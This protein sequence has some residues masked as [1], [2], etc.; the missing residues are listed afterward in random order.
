MLEQDKQADRYLFHKPGVAEGITGMLMR[1]SLFLGM[2]LITACPVHAQP[3]SWQ[4]G[5]AAV[6]ITPAAPMW[7]AGYASRDHVSDGTIHPL[8]VKALALQDGQ[9]H[10]AVIVTSDV[11]GFPK[12]MSVRICERL[13]K[14]LNLARA[15]ILLNSSHTHSG[16]VIL[17]SLMCMYPLDAAGLELVKQETARIEDAVV[18]AAE[19][20]FAG[21][22]PARLSSGGGTVRFAVNRR[23][24]AEAEVPSLNELKGPVDHAVP[25]LL[26]AGEDGAPIAVL[27]GYACHATVLSGFQWCG[28]YPGFAQIEV[29]KAHPGAVAMFAAGCGADINPLPRRSVELARQYGRELAFAVDEVLADTMKPLDPTLATR[30]TETELQLEAAP[31]RA[32]FEE[33]RA[34]AA[35]YMSNA[36]ADQL[37]ELDA[38]RP[39]RSSYPYCAQLWRIGNQTLV[40]LGGEVVVDYAITIKRMLGRETFVFGF[41]NDLMSYIPSLRVLREGGYEG[42]ASQ[43]EYGMPAQWREDIESRV[44]DAVRGLAADTGIA[45]KPPE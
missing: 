39:L 32:H 29:E 33:V 9:G 1:G 21:L 19:K 37:R 23:N 34:K 8:W 16:P 22:R 11:L 28:D 14:G 10:R 3:A 17:D 13:Q 2:V 18:A 38:G 7:L 24:N 6:D 12:P 27:F 42:A 44:L 5:A 26:A 20:A 41:S 43:L 4:A 15:D 30:Y 35:P 45:V 40:A 25:V 36:A 31:D